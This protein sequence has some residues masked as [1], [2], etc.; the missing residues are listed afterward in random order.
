MTQEE[1][2]MDYPFQQWFRGQFVAY[3][4]Q[5]ELA[6]HRPPHKSEGGVNLT[7]PR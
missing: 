5:F 7:P 6:N 4:D 3:Q 2:W 1:E